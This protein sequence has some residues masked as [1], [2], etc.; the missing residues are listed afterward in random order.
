MPEVD[1]CALLARPP[2]AVLRPLPPPGVLRE[3]PNQLSALTALADLS[4]SSNKLGSVGA[5]RPLR[6]LPLLPSLQSLRL[7]RWAGALHWSCVVP[8]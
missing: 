6:H 3:V 8:A 7:D 5:G 1:A 2:T 4:L